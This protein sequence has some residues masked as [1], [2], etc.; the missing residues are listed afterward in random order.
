MKELSIEEK[1]KAYDEAIKK[2]ESLYKAAEPMSG[3]NVLLETVFPELKESEDEEIRKELL[4]YFQNW[5]GNADS[6][7][8]ATKTKDIVAWLEKQKSSKAFIVEKDK[9]YVCIKNFE[10]SD[11]SCAYIQGHL[12]KGDGRGRLQNEQGGWFGFWENSG[13]KYFRLATNK[14]LIEN[15]GEHKPVVDTDIKMESETYSLL[16]P[17]ELYHALPK[18]LQPLWKKE[19]DQAYINGRNDER[20]KHKP[21]WSEE[22]WKL[23][24]E[25]RKYIVGIMGDKPDFTPNKIYEGFL[26]L[27]DRLKSLRPQKQWKP[28]GEQMEA[29]KGVQEG[30]FRLGIL[31]S[32]YQDLMKLREE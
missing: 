2:A 29:L 30:V 1:A 6:Y 18:D 24:D 13:E 23:L 9:W 25:I 22:D 11:G 17:S 27:I 28:S 16:I 19:I 20:K 31:A 12:Y 4:T 14:E 21:E 5:A 32:L 7:F 26:K 10:M 8:G 3:C 15:Q